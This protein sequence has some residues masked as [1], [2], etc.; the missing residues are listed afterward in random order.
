L[1]EAAALAAANKRVANLLSK[2][3]GPVATAI[4][5]HYF[6]SPSEF[7]LNAAIQKAEHA[8]Q[9]LA[10]SRQY[11]AALAQLAGLRTPVDAFFESV[12]INAEE[13][14]VR[15]NRYALLAKLRGLFLGVADISLLG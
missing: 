8:V 3:E 9:P 14:S 7:V 1:P 2:A 15:S 11:H 12:L 6:E 4:Q 10:A 13:P 5:A